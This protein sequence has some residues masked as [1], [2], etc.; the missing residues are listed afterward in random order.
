MQ[1]RLLTLSRFACSGH[2]AVRGT[3]SKILKQC[4]LG[5]EE[6]EAWWGVL[7][8]LLRSALLVLGK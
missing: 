3:E 8:F 1:E 5:C 4:P 7:L 2:A 6:Q